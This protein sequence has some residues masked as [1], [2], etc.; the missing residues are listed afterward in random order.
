MPGRSWSRARQLQIEWR[1]PEVR[2]D[3]PER[4]VRLP[5]EEAADQLF[6][7]PQP[8]HE[9]LATIWHDPDPAAKMAAQR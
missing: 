5:R 4:V 1:N 6:Q 9:A 2:N 7:L 3:R 8:M